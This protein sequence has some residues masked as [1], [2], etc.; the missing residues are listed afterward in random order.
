MAIPYLTGN[1]NFWPLLFY[2][3]AQAGRGALTQPPSC[4][5]ALSYHT[6][7]LW[8]L[9][10]IALPGSLSRQSETMHKNITTQVCYQHSHRAYNPLR[11][12]DD[13][14]PRPS[15]LFFFESIF[16]LN[17]PIMADP[18]VTDSTVLLFFPFCLEVILVLLLLSLESSFTLNH[19]M[20]LLYSDPR[21]F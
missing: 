21:T 12:R 1:S 2:T 3:R 8:L 17:I 9:Q 10:I 7:F 6:Y 15:Q 19:Q 18:A 5:G 13:V 14:Q 4:P 20:D 16:P 11:A